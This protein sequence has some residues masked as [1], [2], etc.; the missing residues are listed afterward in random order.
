MHRNTFLLVVFLAIFAA[1]VI[2]VNIGK[3]GASTAEPTPIPTQAPVTQHYSGCGI[4]LE[5]PTTLT[6]MDSAS[7]SAVLIDKTNTD[8][9][10][11]IACQKDIPRPAVSTDAIETLNIGSTS[12]KLYHDASPKDGSK[13]DELIFTHPKTDL[14]VF[15]AG[16]GETF[17]AIIKTV[18][19]LP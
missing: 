15:I 13:I 18:T 1:L 11:V 3:R 10:I 17:N 7:G 19:L 16:F 4:T 8:Q 2:G 6:L 5:F 12:A 9:S 14:D